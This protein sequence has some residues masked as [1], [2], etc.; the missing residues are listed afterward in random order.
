MTCW[1]TPQCILQPTSA[2]DVSKAML[3]TSYI[4]NRFAVR[5]GGH[6][7]NIGFSSVGSEGLLIDLS[8]LDGVS[9]SPD[10][11]HAVIEPGNRWGRVYQTLA[12][13]GRMAVGGRANDVGVGGFMLGGGLSYWSSIHGMAFNKIVNYE[14]VLGNASI[15]NANRTHNEDLWWALRGGGANYGVV[16]K[17]NVETVENGQIWFEGLLIDSSETE[18]FLEVAVE[19]AAAAENDPDASATYNLGPGG[20]AVYLAYNKPVARP[21]IFSPFYKLAHQ[22]LF[23]STIGTWLD[24]HN[25]VSALNPFGSLRVSISVYDRKWEKR[26]REAAVLLALSKR[27]TASWKS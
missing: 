14:V 10:G 26:S 15:I 17:F 2:D 20:G 27:P 11:A 16:T 13:D 3:L 6:N 7:P 22:P 12:S 21:S 9:L 5:S 1:L 8:R 4:G 24:Y 23:N 25:A 18:K 19:F